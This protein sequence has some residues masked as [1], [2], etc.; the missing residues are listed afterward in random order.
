LVLGSVACSSE[1]QP[2]AQPPAE[3][4][5]PDAPIVT[6]KDAAKDVAKEAAKPPP[7]K[8]AG[9]ETGSS[10]DSGDG[11]DGAPLP[12]Y[13]RLLSET[14][15]YA[16][17]AKGTLGTGVRAYTVRYPLWSDGAEKERWIYLPTGEKIDTSDMDFWKYPV[18]TKAWKQFSVG[19]KRIETRLQWK[20]GP[21][22]EDWVMIAYQWKSDGSDA[23]AVPFGVQN[24]SGTTHDIPAIEDC[25]FCHENMRDRL[26]GFNAIQLSHTLPGVKIADLISENSLTAPPSGPFTLPG[27]GAATEDVASA[28]LGY[29]HGNCGDCHNK[30][31]S[32]FVTID[33]QLWESTKK[34]DTVENTNAFVTAVNLP[35]PGSTTSNRIVPGDPDHSQI[36]LRMGMT[37]S[38]QMPPIARE[39][40]DKVGHDKIRAWIASMPKLTDGGVD[41]GGAK[42]GG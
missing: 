12:R 35:D 34:I 23:V 11:S 3:A 8:D 9:R 22:L 15:L 25:Q 39:T 28:A 16:D 19:G 4:G 20:S 13:K 36:W 30:S 26:L 14:G 42:D 38:G 7:V 21:N 29:L 40:V 32:V 6:H 5:T 37:G 1:E 41:A 2:A 33:M 27:A 10:A 24:A 18:G 17:I 31:S